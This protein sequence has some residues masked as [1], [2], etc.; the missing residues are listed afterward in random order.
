MCLCVCVCVC[1]SMYV[2]VYVWLV[3]TSLQVWSMELNAT[4]GTG[5]V[6]HRLPR[7]IVVWC[8]GVRGGLPVAV[9]ADSPFTRWR[10]SCQVTENV[11]QLPSREDTGPC[12][13][14]FPCTGFT[15]D[16]FTGITELCKQK[17]ITKCNT[18]ALCFHYSEHGHGS[19][20]YPKYTVLLPGLTKHFQMNLLLVHL[21][22]ESSK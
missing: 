15:L 13:L 2:H 3:A 20:I 7:R 9:W 12:S 6:A 4:A 16:D 5:S 21:W 1:V 11:S 14:F 10:S 19:F 18:V 17:T 22:Q 8:A